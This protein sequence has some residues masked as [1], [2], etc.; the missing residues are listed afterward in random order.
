MIDKYAL[1][2]NED[3]EQCVLGAILIDRNIRDVIIPML[4]PET[5]HFEKNQLVFSA[6]SKLYYNHLPIDAVT[7][8]D[9]LNRSEAIKK[10][11]GPYYLTELCNRVTSSA[12]AEYHTIKLCELYMTRQLRFLC[13][14]FKNKATEPEN[15]I[16]QLNDDLQNELLKLNY[17]AASGNNKNIAALVDQIQDR[18]LD[19]KKNPTKLSG[20]PSGFKELDRITGGWQNTDLIIVAA[21]PAMGKTAF[22]LNMAKNQA[23]YG[24]ASLIFSLEMGA[25]QLTSRLISIGANHSS[26]NIYNGKFNDQ[27]FALNILPS[28][29]NVR[30]LPISINDNAG[31]N[32]IQLKNAVRKE[33][34]EKD[35][36]VVY[37]DYLQ[38]MSGKGENRNNEISKI[39]RELK[40]IAKDFNI[41]VIVLSQLSR[42]VESR[43]DK[44]PML[45]D[46]RDSG[47]IEQDAD[48]VLFLYRPEYYGIEY[49]ENNESL[50]GLC[51]IMVSKHRNGGT[52]SIFLEFKPEITKFKDK[53]VYEYEPE[54]EPEPE[55]VF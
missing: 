37:L 12:N 14:D 10:V 15:D 1:I 34:K 7:V 19:L 17:L 6:I 55:P 21:R 18:A 50:K 24:N 22:I 29:D 31:I 32:I 54:P 8:S 42:A 16:L 46:L 23:E 9:E 33:I 2:V 11:G 53:D 25:E 43:S 5:F 40:I 27:E 47:A 48:M 39:S 45:S 36:K 49:N 4:I 3:Y 28:M 30:T 13:E 44:R 51:E 26:R 35:I 20:L 52:G 38:L 41:P